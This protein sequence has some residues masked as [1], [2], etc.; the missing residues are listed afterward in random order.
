MAATVANLTLIAGK[1]GQMHT[2][3]RQVF[4]FFIWL[5]VL[6]G[7]FW[8]AGCGFEHLV[9]HFQRQFAVAASKMPVFG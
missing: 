8:E 6:K 2:K 3:I 4:L 1:T 5:E 7:M 9:R